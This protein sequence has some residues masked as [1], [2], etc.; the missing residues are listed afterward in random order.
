M[1]AA[2]ISPKVLI[3]DDQPRNLDALEAMLSS[4][5]CVLIRAESADAW[6]ESWVDF[7]VPG[8]TLPLVE[9]RLAAFVARALAR[10]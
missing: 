5:G 6:Y 4:L 10:I 9:E 1:S 8:L 3:V 2:A 7:G